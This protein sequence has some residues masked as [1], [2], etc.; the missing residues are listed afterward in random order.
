[1]TGDPAV[2]L[3]QRTKIEVIEVRVR[4]KDEIDLRQFGYTERGG[5]ESPRSESVSA[6]AR[7]N[8]AE[9]DRIG[10]NG[11]TEKVDQHRGMSKPGGG[12]AR[13]APTVR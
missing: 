5:D 3:S 8:R 7:S 6:E 2:E 13:I 4:K 9:Q 10:K 11:E 1:M 12:D